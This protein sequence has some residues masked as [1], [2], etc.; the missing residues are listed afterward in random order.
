KDMVGQSYPERGLID[1]LF[2]HG[3]VD[4]GRHVDPDNDRLFTWWAPWRN[5]RQRNIGWRL[6]YVAA[7]HALVDGAVTCKVYRDVGSSAPAPG[8]ACANKM[9]RAAVAA[10]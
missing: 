6:D 3:L 1:E 7:H 5:M 2:S 9:L 4:L 10:P 8:S